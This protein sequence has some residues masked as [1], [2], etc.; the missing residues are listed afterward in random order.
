MAKRKSSS[1][2]STKRK[3][4]VWILAVA[5]VIIILIVYETNK[6][7]RSNDNPQHQPSDTAVMAPKKVQSEVRSYYRSHNLPIGWKIGDTM[8]IAPNRL[9]GSVR[10]K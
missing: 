8:L 2:F 10:A 4:L 6:E 1:G 5:A 9:E 7:L 3:R